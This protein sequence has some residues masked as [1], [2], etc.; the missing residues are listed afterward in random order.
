MSNTFILPTI[1]GGRYR[2]VRFLMVSGETSVYIGHDT[3]T[4]KPITV[5]EFYVPG[6]MQRRENGEI[7]VLAG[8]EVFIQVACLR[9]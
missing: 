7:A 3:T 8:R 2:L 9:F 6:L 4:D 5:R 1:P